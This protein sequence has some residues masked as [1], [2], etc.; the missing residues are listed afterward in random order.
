M[1]SMMGQH[2]KSAKAW[3][4][5]LGYAPRFWHYLATYDHQKRLILLCTAII[6]LFSIINNKMCELNLLII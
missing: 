5:F 4:D 1:A 2:R 6:I 3:S